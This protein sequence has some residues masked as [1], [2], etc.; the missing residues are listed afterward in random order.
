MK[1]Q[2]LSCLVV[3]LK[4][5]AC[6]EFE[7]WYNADGQILKNIQNPILAKDF[8]D[9]RGLARFVRSVSSVNNTKVF[10]I[11][12]KVALGPCM[13]SVVFDAAIRILLI[14]LFEKITR[15]V[16]RRFSLKTE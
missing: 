12:M 14:L 4:S 16:E 9:P 5:H 11:R 8:Q 13:T 2:A 15:R 3:A 6:N 10:L 7:L 1:T